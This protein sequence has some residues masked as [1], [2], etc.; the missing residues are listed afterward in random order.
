MVGTQEAYGLCVYS[1]QTIGPSSEVSMCLQLSLCD[2]ELGVE[3][4]PVRVQLVI[5]RGLLARHVE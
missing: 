1:K 5:P 4:I 2:R 3:V